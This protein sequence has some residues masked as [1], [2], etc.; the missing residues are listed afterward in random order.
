MD[1]IVGI[2]RFSRGKLAPRY[3]GPYEII[4]KINPVTYQVALPPVMENMHNVFH[5]S[6]LREYLR[7]PLHVIE[8]THMLLKDDYVYKE[9]PIQIVNHQIKRLRNKEI[10]LVK[11]AW[12][13]HRR[14]YVTWKTEKDMMKRYPDLILLDP[15]FFQNEGI[16]VRFFV[17]VCELKALL[18]S[19]HEIV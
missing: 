7:D 16:P 8:S 4:Q 17:S 19:H 1:F 15:T 5:V 10:P 18:T 14:T 9:Q 2:P 13:N 11:V 3:I 6:M 12:Q